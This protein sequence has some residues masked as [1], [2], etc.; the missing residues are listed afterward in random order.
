[1]F[2]LGCRI[3]YALTSRSLPRSCSSC[4]V[5]HLEHT[6]LCRRELLVR[7]CFLVQ[8]MEVGVI[9][10][11]GFVLFWRAKASTP[12]GSTLVIMLN[13]TMTRG[14]WPWILLRSLRMHWPGAKI[15]I[16]W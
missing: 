10:K 7:S 12:S 14:R 13:L 3:Y 2:F 9:W 5:A 11:T 8:E 4:S 16:F 15:L 6:I 1:P